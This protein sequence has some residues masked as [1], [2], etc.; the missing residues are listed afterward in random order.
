MST[1]VVPQFYFTSLRQNVRWKMGFENS[2]SKPCYEYEL[3]SVLASSGLLRRDRPR[4]S[5]S[6]HLCNFDWR[7]AEAEADGKGRPSLYKRSMAHKQM[8]A[9]SRTRSKDRG[10][11][12]RLW[13]VSYYPLRNGHNLRVTTP[14]ATPKL[15]PPL[16]STVLSC[17]VTNA[18]HY[19]CLAFRPLG[20]NLE[21]KI[22]V[23]GE[24]QIRD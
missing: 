21:E 23:R 14:L 1:P 12:A 19:A 10:M 3:L 13:V 15:T 11:L 16:F 7:G 2:G 20:K 22:G 17:W 5:E 24:G 18:S 4:P 8:I 9:L 6:R